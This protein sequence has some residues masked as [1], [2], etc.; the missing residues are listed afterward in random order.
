MVRRH[1]CRRLAGMLHDDD[2][3]AIAPKGGVFTFEA[4]SLPNIY[5]LLF[6]PLPTSPV[7]GGGV[8]AAY[9][10]APYPLAG[11]GGMGVALAQVLG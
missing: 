10:C 3:N 7:D 4:V 2:G 8:A 9:A 11:R 5:L 1:S 6:T